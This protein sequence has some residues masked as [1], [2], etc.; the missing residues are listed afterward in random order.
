M[1]GLGGLQKNATVR[2]SLTFGELEVFTCAGLSSL[3]T[4]ACAWVTLHVPLLLEINAEIAIELFERTGDAET[5]CAG[6]TVEATT[7]GFHRDIDLFGHIDSFE[8]GEC[9]TGKL[10]GLEV[11]IGILAVDFDLTGAAGQADTCDS[12]LATAD[13]NKCCFA[14]YYIK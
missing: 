2:R 12:S 4:L 7:M 13:S 5:G 10:L 1:H 6:L 11:A 14:H 3:L 9:R 8:G